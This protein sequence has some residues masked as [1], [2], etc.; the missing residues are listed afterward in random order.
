MSRCRC[1]CRTR[2]RWRRPPRTQSPPRARLGG[3][4]AKRSGKSAKSAKP[5]KPAKSATGGPRPASKP[6]SSSSK[7]TRSSARS[8]KPAKPAKSSPGSVRSSPKPA[9]GSAG[10]DTE[11]DGP[12]TGGS[13]LRE[14]P[15]DAT[16]VAAKPK[17]RRAAVPTWPNLPS[18]TPQP[19][20][21]VRP[22]SHRPRRSGGP[23]TPSRAGQGARTQRLALRRGAG[24]PLLRLKVAGAQ[25]LGEVLEPIGTVLPVRTDLTGRISG[26]YR[27][28]VETSACPRRC[29]PRTRPAANSASS[30]CPTPSCMPTSGSRGP[31]RRCGS[32]PSELRYRWFPRGPP[33]RMDGLPATWTLH[34]D[35][36][37]PAFLILDDLSP[38]AD[39]LISLHLVRKAHEG[40]DVV[41][42]FLTGPMSFR[43]TGSVAAPIRMGA[44]PGRAASGWTGIVGS[45]TGNPSRPTTEAPSPWRPWARTRFGWRRTRMSIGNP[46]R[47]C[48]VRCTCRQ[49]SISGR[50]T[51]V[52]RSSS[53]R[54]ADSA[55]GNSSACC[56]RRRRPRRTCSHR[57]RS[58]RPGGGC[59]RFIPAIAVLVLFIGAGLAGI[60]VS[61]LGRKPIELGPVDEGRPTT[62]GSTWR[63][64][65][66]SSP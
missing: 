8:V 63:R 41:L 16:T 35:G 26:W 5:A 1:P 9:S 43:R 33:L 38:A 54:H 48:T 30:M 37:L 11:A 52:S 50:P 51:A 56:S 53:W 14:A 6:A 17:A 46:Y 32:S 61:T 4:A 25:P 40:W 44:N 59:P 57:C 24:A 7:K 39:E 2:P 65:S 55:S 18:P 49:C 29:S 36:P 12:S 62:P 28:R 42:R 21:P 64:S 22:S 45:M 58:P 20:S 47:P 23:P 27:L 19:G 60:I 66:W 15:M 3:E 31:L 13:T 10:R 34:R